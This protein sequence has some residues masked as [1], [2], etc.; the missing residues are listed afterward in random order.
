VTASISAV[1]LSCY[2]ILQGWITFLTTFSLWP[3]LSGS[4]SDNHDATS[5]RFEDKSNERQTRRI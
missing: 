3:I 1:S 5:R 4:H 2:F